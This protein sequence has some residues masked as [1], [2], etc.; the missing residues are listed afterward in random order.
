MI[1]ALIPARGGSRRVPRK[2][3]KLLAGRPLIEWT[4]EAAK[5]SAWLDVIAVTTEDD[6]IHRVAV[7]IG[8]ASVI[9]RP[10]VLASDT[11]NIYDAIKHAIYRMQGNFTHVCLLHP[12]SPLRIAADIDGCCAAAVGEPSCNSVVS[13]T[14]GYPIMEVP[15]GAVYVGRKD[16]LLAGGNFD[17]DKN[18]IQYEMPAKRSIDINLPEDFAEAERLIAA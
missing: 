12:T 11:A 2:N 17:T 8:G 16:W 10:M 5:R 9:R 13:V 7:E 3:L 18:Q 1:L 14:G 15:N 6:E 4:I